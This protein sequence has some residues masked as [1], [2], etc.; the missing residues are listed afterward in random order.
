M[1]YVSLIAEALRG[2]PRLVFWTAALTQGLL[3]FLI[4]SLFYSAPPGD[5][6]TTLAIGHEF[7]LG[8]YLGPPL[9]FWLGEIAFRIAG[10]FGVYLLAQ[11]CIVVTYWAVFTLGRA[12][13]GVRHAALS[14]LL[15]VGIT[16]FTVP[17]VDFGP[18]VLA[19]PLWALALLHYWRALGEEKRGIWFLLALDL[20]LL[21]LTSY[22]GLI[23][24]VLLAVF[25]AA[26]PQGR[27]ALS[28]GEPWVCAVLLLIVVFP[29]VWWLA[30]QGDLVLSGWQAS[31][32]TVG[33]LPAWAW[34]AMLLAASHLGLILL[35]LLATG[36]PRGRRERARPPEI[37]RAPAPPFGRTYVYIFA[38]VPA[39]TAIVI[40]A[41]G[42]R[43]GP[44]GEIAPLLVLS[45]LAVIT[46][47]GDRVLLYRERL[48]SSAWVG[49]LV[50]PPLVAVAGIAVTPWI[51]SVDP[52]VAQ[53]ANA[54]GR[55]FGETF[56][57][58]TGK[59]LQYVAG[60]QRLA[61]LIAL[62][63]PSRPHVYFDWAPR[64]STWATAADVQKVGGVLVWPATAAS[65]APPKSLK[66]QFPTLVPEVPHS[67]TRAVQGFLPSIRLGWAMLRPQAETKP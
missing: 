19:A 57:R 67:F 53:P 38:L 39:L 55:F 62:A 4:P 63:A 36:R 54:E 66:A 25:T 22:V 27:H 18:A 52:K 28:Y 44:L 29:H 41:A 14:I 64:W 61:P 11:A 35:I 10:I 24:V 37:D 13:V 31:A 7:L 48:V 26:T 20:G 15:M 56:Q 2:R 1:H 51:A 42:G 33:R 5:L 23:L 3:W 49:I 58:R 46:A 34:L 65:T 6:P 9:A 43:L 40:V 47:A 60:D 21:L 59:P 30:H 50:V 45:G 32:A 16:A 8:S 17:S 12:I